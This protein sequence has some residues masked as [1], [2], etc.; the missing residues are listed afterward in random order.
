MSAVEDLAR[1]WRARGFL[2][3]PDITVAECR[4]RAP[5]LEPLYRRAVEEG[6]RGSLTGAGLDPD[7]KLSRKER[8]RLRKAMR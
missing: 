1:E 2:A 5:E 4:R 7:R 6:M 8:R 3:Q